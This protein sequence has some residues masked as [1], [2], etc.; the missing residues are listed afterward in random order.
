M[1]SKIVGNGRD[2]QHQQYAPS[3]P[4]RM[5][6]QSRFTGMAKASILLAKAEPFTFGV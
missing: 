2:V 4:G 1:V 5:T 3:N 6:C